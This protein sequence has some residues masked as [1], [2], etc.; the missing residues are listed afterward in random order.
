[1]SRSVATASS[2][3]RVALLATTALGLL[4]S[5]AAFARVGVTSATDG[6]PLGKPPAE[7]ERVLRIGIDVQANEVIR[8]GANDRA[9]LVFLDGTALTVGPNAQLAIDKFV[10][11]PT[12]KTGEIAINATKGVMRLV[13]GRISKTNPIT[14]TTPSSTIGIRGGICV[15]DV[16]PNNTTSTFLF[17]NNM[18][19]ASNGGT[20][21]VT[22]PGSQVTTNAGAAP[23]APT[24]VSQGALSGQIGQLEGRSGGGGNPGAQTTVTPSSPVILTGTQS[25]ASQPSPQ[26]APTNPV[27]SFSNP[28][29]WNPVATLNTAAINRDAYNV[30]PNSFSPPVVSL[31]NTGTAT[32]NGTFSGRSNSGTFSGTLSIGWSFASQTGNLSASDGP[33]VGATAPLSLSPGTLGFSGPLTVTNLFGVTQGTGTVAGA[34]GSTAAGAV[35]GTF[36][37]TGTSSQPFNGSFSARR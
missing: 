19:V 20:Q 29:Q 17:G 27:P 6:D 33:R 8:T 31:P 37:G 16:Q 36:S 13:G 11:D 10:Y 30:G 23:G 15:L 5:G 24:M 34:F 28:G 4:G 25:L 35:S 7:A 32:Y 21:N 26:V 3:L 18:T 1:M 2:I 14:V 12:T 22:R 9:H